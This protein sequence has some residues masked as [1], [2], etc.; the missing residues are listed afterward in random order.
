MEYQT[1]HPAGTRQRPVGEPAG[2]CRAVDDAVQGRPTPAWGQSLN[3]FGRGGAKV[4][5]FDVLSL[6][7]TS[8]S[9]MVTAAATPSTTGTPV[10]ARTRSI[11]P[12][13]PP[14]PRQMTS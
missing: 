9:A 12:A 10:A 4:R 13:I 2:R 7:R 3:R 6:I 8:P 5:T 1:G 14:Q 11:S